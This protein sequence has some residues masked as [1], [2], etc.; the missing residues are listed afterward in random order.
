MGFIYLEILDASFHSDSVIGAF[1]VTSQ[2]LLIAIGLGIGAFWVR[3][4]TVFMVR[5]KTLN[6]YKYLEHGAHY[7]VAILTA[8]LLIS[9]L[10]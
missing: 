2:I 9:L 10:L 3:S 5:R 8:A 6:T 1:A 7:T 4:I